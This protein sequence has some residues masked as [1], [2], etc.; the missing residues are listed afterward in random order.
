MKRLTL[1][2]GSHKEGFVELFI[3][4]RLIQGLAAAMLAL[5]TPIFLYET[6]GELFWVV[7]LFY[8]AVSFSYVLVLV[9]AM[10]ITNCIG[11]SRALALAALFSVAQYAIMYFMNTNN[12]LVLLVP[13]GL[14]IIG[15]R[16]WHWVPYHVDF[17]EF[18]KGGNRGRDVSLMLATVA[19]MGVI[20]PILAGFI[21]ENA[22]YNVL[23]AIGLILMV[24]ASVSYLFVPETGEEFTWNYRK[25]LQHLF[26]KDFRPVLMSEFA[27]GAEVVVNIVA[28]PV[29][30][31]VVLNGEVLEVGALSTVIVG[32]TII[33]QLM[34]GKYLDKAKGNN[35]R[36]L[37]VGSVLYA[38]GW[39]L[40]IF[41]LSVTQIFFIGLYH[42]IS[43]IFTSTP[44]NALFY[45][46]SGE[47]GRYIDEF[48][49]MKEMSHHA[50]RAGG[51]LAMFG[52]TL[53]FSV[54]WT[55]VIGAVSTL[56]LNMIYVAKTK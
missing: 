1:S 33:I 22:G 18:T 4:K 42:N 35:V 10:R 13:L 30:L 11:F 29:F 12:F 37:Q 56:F 20:G 53:F 17:A 28:W 16:T 44:Y 36:T 55:F 24:C 25:T 38:I 41:V 49:V 19:F 26:S 5:F 52:L 27:G 34:V 47:Q 43:K 48:T 3:S 54:E 51:L 39:I 7:V 31:F 8:F 40:K 2:G 21:I 9:P 6:S 46:M 50:G 45:D 32:V 23:F 14:T 15:F